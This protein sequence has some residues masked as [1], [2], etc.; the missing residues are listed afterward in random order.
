[1]TCKLGPTIIQRGREKILESVEG[2]EAEDDEKEDEKDPRD[3]VVGGTPHLVNV[4]Y[5]TI[6]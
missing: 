2:M 3:R 6:G 5:I 1:M 4:D